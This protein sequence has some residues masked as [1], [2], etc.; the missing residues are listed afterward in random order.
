ML[1]ELEKGSQEFILSRDPICSFIRSR[2][3]LHSF[4]EEIIFIPLFKNSMNYLKRYPFT[5]F[6]RYHSLILS[7]DPIHSEE[8]PCVHSLKRSHSDI[9]SKCSH[10]SFINSLKGSHHSFTQE[11][12][13][14]L[15]SL[16]QEVLFTRFLSRP[17]S[18]ILLSK[19]SHSFIG[20]SG[21]MN[22]FSP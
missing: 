22:S 20:S 3:P 7:S 2:D 6:L 14:S 15:H 16:S 10:I 12:L 17:H 18:F 19:R 13:C 11:I 8:I 5:Y 4:Y 21:P 1:P 9:I